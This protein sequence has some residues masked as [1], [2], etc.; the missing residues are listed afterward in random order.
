MLNYALALLVVALVSAIYG[1][2][3][4]TG[5]AA[6]TARQISF[7]ACGLFILAAITRLLRG[8]H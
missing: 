1:F 7:G 5:D 3:G 8:R 6:E 2:G 4:F